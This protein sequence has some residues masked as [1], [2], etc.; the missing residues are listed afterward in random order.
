M[1]IR[2]Y[3]ASDDCIEVEG[4]EGADEFATHEPGPVKWGG[5]LRAPDGSVLR[6]YAVLTSCWSIALGQA[7]EDQP[8]PAWP[9]V[10]AQHRSLP[11]STMVEIDAPDG[12]E[13]V[14]V[15]PGG[16]ASC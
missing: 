15:W 7:T 16:E 4:C 3:G 8:F 1:K 13:L 10:T 9:V 11:Y 2:I 6:A 5:D 12:T 14:N